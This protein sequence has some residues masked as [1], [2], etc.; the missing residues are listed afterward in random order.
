MPGRTM[1]A[2]AREPSWT[3]EEMMQTRVDDR[4]RQQKKAVRDKDSTYVEERQ[5]HA[6]GYAHLRPSD[7]ASG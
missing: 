7:A 6:L 1:G 3:Q 4:A 2:G 5:R